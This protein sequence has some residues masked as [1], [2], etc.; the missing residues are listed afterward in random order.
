MPPKKEVPL[1]EDH[2]RK[3]Y[4]HLYGLQPLSPSRFANVVQRI[5]GGHYQLVGRRTKTN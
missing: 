4:W 3:R 1:A 2:K 5:I